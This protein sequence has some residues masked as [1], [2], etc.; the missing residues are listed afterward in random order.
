MATP[1]R[2]RAA[3]RAPPRLKPCAAAPVPSLR[4]VALA[5]CALF[6]VACGA[7]PEPTSG[8][9]DTT[10]PASVRDGSNRIITVEAPP[11]L[12]LVV[13]GGP[14]RLLARLGVRA[15]VAPEDVTVARIRAA[16]PDLVV[17]GPGMTARETS[18]ATRTSS[19]SWTTPVFV[20]PGGAAPRRR[21]R[22]GRARRA[23]QPRRG[24]ASARALAAP[25]AR[26]HR[27]DA[28]R[29]S[30]PLTV[31]V[32]AGFGTSIQRTTLLARLLVLA[33]GAA[34]RARRRR[35]DG[36]RQGAPPARPRRLR[37][38]DDQ[39]RHA[40]A[41]ALAAR[42]AHAALG[43]RRPRLRRRSRRGARGHDRLR[44]PALARALSC[45]PPSSSSDALRRGHARRDGDARLARA[46]RR[47]ACSAR[48]RAASASSSTSRA[49]RAR[50]ASRCAT[51]AR[52]APRRAT[53]RRSR[54]CG[55]SA[56]RCSPTRSRSTSPGADVLPSLTD[57]I[58]FLAY[59]DARPA[60]EQLAAA[61]LKLAV[62]ANWDVSLTDVLARLGLAD[63]L[64]GDRHGGGGRRRQARSAALP[65]GARAAR[66]R[67]RA[68]PST[69]ATTP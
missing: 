58:S 23:H 42:P 49:A 30:P 13:T 27:E 62:V 34:G 3:R 60:L 1:D 19:A 48:S 36:Q 45:T 26:G 43:G 17:V 69:S 31:Y 4:L 46:A 28:S 66:R 9:L 63:A 44:A 29:T 6:A 40:R 32:D 37:R 24:R 64:R 25:P 12:V 16:H 55:W 38:H 10:Y 20:M 61:G 52:T 59:D 2:A 14:E 47:R 11:R 51:T 22:R 18:S 50:C 7:K 33:G 53:R 57:A 21:A 5:L 41:A 56:P 39:R 68:V 15:A 65:G 8:K 35:R 67:G 54:P